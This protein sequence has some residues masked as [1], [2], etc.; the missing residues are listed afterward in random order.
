MACGKRCGSTRSS[1]AISRQHRCGCC[2]S[3]IA[4]T[5]ACG[6][7]RARTGMVVFAFRGT[8]SRTRSRASSRLSWPTYRSVA[9]K[10]VGVRATWLSSGG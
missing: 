2:P 9:R 7:T 1:P 4:E 5:P 6:G 3:W 8:T 10:L